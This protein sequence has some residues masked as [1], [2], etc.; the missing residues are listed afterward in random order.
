MTLTLGLGIDQ[1][2]FVSEMYSVDIDLP[3]DLHEVA[4]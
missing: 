4:V 2:T 1:K 3:N